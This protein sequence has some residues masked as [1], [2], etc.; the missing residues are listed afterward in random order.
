MAR[1][2]AGMRIVSLTQ[3]L[4]RA[5]FDLQ[6]ANAELESARG[7]RHAYEPVAPRAVAEE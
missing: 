2:R 3:D 7:G 4:R 6:A 1:V 5:V